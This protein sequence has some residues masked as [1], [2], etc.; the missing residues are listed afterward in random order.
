M[1]I[2][3]LLVSCWNIVDPH[4]HALLALFDCNYIFIAHVACL[5]T[6]SY[7]VLYRN[8]SSAFAQPFREV[9]LFLPF[10]CVPGDSLISSAQQKDK[11]VCPKNFSSRADEQIFCHTAANLKKYSGDEQSDCAIGKALKTSHDPNAVNS[12]H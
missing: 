7:T 6:N 9:K 12:V 10:A 8:A 5:V 2:I 1:A 4:L 3:V 11:R